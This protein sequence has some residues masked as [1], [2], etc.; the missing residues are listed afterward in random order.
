[1]DILLSFP[2]IYDNESIVMKLPIALK[3]SLKDGAK[4]YFAQLIL[5]CIV[6]INYRAIAQAD[7][8]ITGLSAAG[9]AIISFFTIKIITKKTDY[10]IASWTGYILGSV[11]G[12]LTGIFISKLMLGA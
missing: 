6:T 4:L 3:M 10:P 7:Y 11:C 12:D 5:Y 9:I 1:M 2:Y 8:L